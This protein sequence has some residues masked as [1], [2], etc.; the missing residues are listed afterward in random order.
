MTTKEFYEDTKGVFQKEQ[1]LERYDFYNKYNIEKESLY[2]DVYNYL[3]DHGY[4]PRET[5]TILF[6]HL[7]VEIY[8]QIEKETVEEEVKKPFSQFYLDF[9]GSSIDMGP[10]TFHSN[11]LTRSYK[12]TESDRLAVETYGTEAYRIAKEIKKDKKILKKTIEKI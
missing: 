8:H 5:N 11:M 4:D 7:I 12:S 1:F 2:F 9:S 6:S 3:I 10:K